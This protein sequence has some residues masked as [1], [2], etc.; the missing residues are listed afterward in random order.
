M[1]VVG[2]GGRAFDLLKFMDTQE[3]MIEATTW[4]E[5]EESFLEFPQS[6][7]PEVGLSFKAEPPTTEATAPLV[8][9]Q[10]VSG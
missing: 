7:G 5:K 9:D 8:P 6:P 4:L 10:S 1:L 3:E 2:F